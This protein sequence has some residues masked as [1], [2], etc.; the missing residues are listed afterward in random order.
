MFLICM[1]ALQSIP[2]E[3]TEAA[4]VDGAS[5]WQVF[6]SIKFP[7]L[8][9]STAPLLISS[10]AFNF[11]NFNT[12]YLLTGGGPRMAG[13]SENVGHTDLLITLVYKTA[14]EGGTRDYGLASALSILIFLIV[15]IVSAIA[16]SR[17]KALEE[18][19]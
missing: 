14:F 10:F 1:G 7:L 19:N 8:L 12:I 13:V 5:G 9:V 4:R 2:D 18:L 11:N 15:A 16:F 6:R 17:T 3:L